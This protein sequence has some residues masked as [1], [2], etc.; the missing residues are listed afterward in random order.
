MK[1]YLDICCFNRPF[2]AQEQ[3]RVRL[4]TE[5]KLQIQ[6]RIRHK[7]LKLVWSYMLDYENA[8]NPFAERKD[9]I[10]QWAGLA[11][12]DVEENLF[13]LRKAAQLQRLGIKAKDALHLA[14][15]L[16]AKCDYF[17]TT[18]RS[19]LKKATRLGDLRVMNP[20]DFFMTVIK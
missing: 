17:L 15:A 1:I 7:R 9:A 18:D 6:G 19:L 14:C 16:A 2:D 8:A 3:M 11:A 20:V 4:E 12:M 10:A 13:L 5:A